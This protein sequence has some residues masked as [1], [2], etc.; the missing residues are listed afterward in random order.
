MSS[1]VLKPFEKVTKIISAEQYLTKSLIIILLHGLLYFRT[2]LKNQNIS[3]AM[4]R[5]IKRLK[6]E[7]LIVLKTSNTYSLTLAI[8]T[9][10]NLCFKHIGFTDKKAFEEINIEIINKFIAKQRH[11]EVTAGSSTKNP[12]IHEL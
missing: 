6:M 4:L 10:L 8:C 3:K 11:I 2:K 9:F 7:S 12:K 5:V 1:T